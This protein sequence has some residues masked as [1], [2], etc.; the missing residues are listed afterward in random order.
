M[1]SSNQNMIHSLKECN[2]NKVAYVLK[3]CA[4]N[5]HFSTKK[6]YEFNCFESET[7]LKESFTKCFLNKLVSKW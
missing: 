2:Q 7:N 3:K 5:G 1:C 4:I 6:S